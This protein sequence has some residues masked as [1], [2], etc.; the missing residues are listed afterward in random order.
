MALL[1]A[2][3]L[4]PVQ[5]CCYRPTKAKVAHKH[6]RLC[7]LP[8][9]SVQRL[10]RRSITVLQ[11]FS[12]HCVSCLRKALTA[13]FVAPVTCSAAPARCLD[14]PTGLIIWRKSA[15]R[16]TDFCLVTLTPTWCRCASGQLS[17]LLLR[18]SKCEPTASRCDATRLQSLGTRPLPNQD[19]P[20]SFRPPGLV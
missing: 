17:F 11:L 16:S 19:G 20:A 6:H 14:M 3:V 15:D 4:G 18:H 7:K 13:S 2:R 10:C 9:H 1:K 5:L 12:Q 8:C